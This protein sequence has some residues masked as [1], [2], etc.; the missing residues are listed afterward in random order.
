[1]A[2]AE[3]EAALSTWRGDR[4]AAERE[5]PT[6]AEIDGPT[7]SVVESIE[8]ALRPRYVSV[9]PSFEIKVESPPSDSNTAAGNEDSS[10]VP[11]PSTDAKPPL[12]TSPIRPIPFTFRQEPN[13]PPPILRAR[14]PITRGEGRGRGEGR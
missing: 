3:V 12:D 14:S 5:G 4:P 6:M 10:V 7:S 11:N 9:P 13:L 8:A 2:V 1:M